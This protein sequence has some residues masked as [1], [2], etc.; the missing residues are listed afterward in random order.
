MREWGGYGTGMD[1]G[2]LWAWRDRIAVDRPAVIVAVGPV[3]LAL[4]VAAVSE[5]VGD[6]ALVVAVASGGRAAHPAV[7]WV[8][9]DPSEAAGEVMALAQHEADVRGGGVL[10][11]VD[12][13]LAHEAALRYLSPGVGSLPPDSPQESNPANRGTQ[14]RIH[15]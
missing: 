14:E 5:S 2:A 9:G 3:G 6:D 7:V 1:A 13:S 8:E 11:V 10:A 4:F 12:P 15:D